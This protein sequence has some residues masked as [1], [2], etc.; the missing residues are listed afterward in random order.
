MAQRLRHLPPDRIEIRE[1][2]GVVAMFG[3]PFLACGLFMLLTPSGIIPARQTS[4]AAWPAFALMGLAFAGVGAVL[5]FGRRWTTIDRAQRTI[6][7]EIG[8][9]VPLWRETFRIDDYTA[10]SLGF[11]AGDSDSADRF[12]VTLKARAGADL[13][14]CSFTSYADSRACAAAIGE[15][16]GFSLEDASTD[17]PLTLSPEQADRPFASRP[18]QDERTTVDRP[19]GAKSQ[20][21]YDA[22]AVRIAIP[23]ARLHPV[24]IGGHLVPVAI[25]IVIAPRF[26]TFAAGRV[27]ADPFA[28]VPAAVITSFFVFVPAVALAFAVLRSRLGGT[29]VFVSRQGIR[30]RERGAVLTKTVASIDASDILDVD[31]GTRETMVAMA[32]HAAEQRVMQ[33]H[34]TSPPTI[35]PMMQSLIGSLAQFAQGRG[36]IVKTRAGLRAFG[37]GLDDDEI[38]YLHGVIRRALR[39]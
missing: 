31:Y 12:P 29:F 35:S 27:N 37:A 11:S 13:Q 4:P 9:A 22:D 3:L 19:A 28:W 10:V 8:L 14:L 5:T 21:S 6:V 23:A 34:P 39:G 1:G 25:G 33:A 7:R 26:V 15:H 17:H 30:I 16:L 24:V 20:V 38:R 18:K 32:T 2:G 36:L